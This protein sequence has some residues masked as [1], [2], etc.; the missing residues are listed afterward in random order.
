MP[1]SLLSIPPN[2]SCPYSTLVFKNPSLWEK[3][4]KQVRFINWN[5]CELSPQSGRKVFRLPLTDCPVKLYFSSPTGGH[6]A[7]R[8][9]VHFSRYFLRQSAPSGL[10]SSSRKTFHPPGSIV[11]SPEGVGM[12]ISGALAFCVKKNFLAYEQSSKNGIVQTKCV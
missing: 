12:S 7:S 9:E 8:N 10:G 6:H 4:L 11:V 5:I 1:K 2:P 3:Y